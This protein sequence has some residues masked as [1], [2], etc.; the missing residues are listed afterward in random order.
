ME[1]EEAQWLVESCRQQKQVA[2]EELHAHEQQEEDEEDLY[3]HQ[4][5]SLDQNTALPYV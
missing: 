2:A 3:R 1:E 5:A 4:E